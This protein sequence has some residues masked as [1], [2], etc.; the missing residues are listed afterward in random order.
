MFHS[1]SNSCRVS[2]FPRVIWNLSPRKNN[3]KEAELQ[4]NGKS[5][6]IPTWP[7]KLCQ[8]GFHE[9]FWMFGEVFQGFGDGWVWEW[10]C[11]VNR[12]LWS[13]DGK[14]S[15]GKRSHPHCSHHWRRD[16][17]KRCLGWHLVALW[18]PQPLL[19]LER[20]SWWIVS[21]LG[22]VCHQQELGCSLKIYLSTIAAGKS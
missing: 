9:I 17:R 5:W 22:P 12:I 6:R 19:Q 7:P 13:A 15:Q 2:P 16:T 3:A 10:V 4:W 11:A 18:C 1:Q 14:G 8:P 21:G 20:Q